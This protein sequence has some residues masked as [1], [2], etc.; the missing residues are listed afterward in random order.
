MGG[1]VLSNLMPTICGAGL[2][3]PYSAMTIAEYFAAKNRD[4][5]I[6]F[7]DLWRMPNIIGRF[8]YWLKDFPA[9]FLPGRYLF[10]P[11]ETS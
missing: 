8:R 10:Y 9:E 5:L 3:D 6:V 11:F 2:S 7:D 4:V 1:V